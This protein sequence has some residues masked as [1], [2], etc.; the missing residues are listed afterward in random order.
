MLITSLE[1]SKVKFACSLKTASGR[2]K[3]CAF[4]LEGKKLIDEAIKCGY[5]Q[6]AAGTA[7]LLVQCTADA[8]Q[9]AAGAV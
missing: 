5:D 7:D 1:N 4:L 6:G 3:Q 2:K 9:S 8:V